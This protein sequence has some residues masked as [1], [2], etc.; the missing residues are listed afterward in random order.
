MITKTA[1]KN[2]WRNKVRSIVVIASVTI[3]IFA[4]VFA[5]GVMNGAMKQRIGSA[6]DNE[7]SHIQV[8]HP[9]FRSNNDLNYYID[10]SDLVSAE[11]E[12]IKGVEAVVSRM[13]VIGMANTASKSAGVQINGINP[14]DEKEVF[15]LYNEI[16]PGTGGYF[17]NYAGT[18]YA[19]IGVNLAKSLNIIRYIITGEVLNSLAEN[20]V[21]DEVIQKLSQFEGKRFKNEKSFKRELRSVLDPKEEAKYGYVIKEESQNFSKRARLTLT[22]LDS[23][24]NQTGGR[25]RIAGLFDIPNSMYE[26]MQVFIMGNELERL[27]GSPRN[28]SHILAIRISDVDDTGSIAEKIKEIYPELEVMTWTELQPDLAMMSEMTGIMYGF[29]MAIILAALA[30]GIVNTMLMVV[31]ERTRELGML[32]AIGMNK[33]K[34]FRMIM[35]ESVFLS[36]IGGVVGMIVSKV[37]IMLTAKNGISLAGMEEGFEGMGFSAHIYPEIGP[38]FFGLVTVL[39]I[40]TGILSSVYPALKALKLD[41]AEALKTE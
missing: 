28:T 32:T 29:F 39:I 2:I 18:G 3:G 8:T 11:I 35:T 33:K 10:H 31:L 12:K 20:D 4:G 41:P 6:L 16:Y 40:I 30:F 21:P 5:V 13:V 22:F 24:N 36:L 7:V 38:E 37:I 1:W 34:V 17:D 19:F 23:S 27:V 9:D 26:S 25:F 15:S 14:S